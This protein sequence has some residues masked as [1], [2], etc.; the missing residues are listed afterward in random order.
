MKKY[1]VM[2]FCLSCF[3]EINAQQ[4]TIIFDFAHYVNLI[5]KLVSVYSIDQY[6][7]VN[8]GVI[9]RNLYTKP[10]F[11][12]SLDIEQKKKLIF[13]IKEMFEQ[14]EYTNLYRFGHYVIYKMW[15]E[16]KEYNTVEI[17]QI[18]MELYLKYYFYPGKDRIIDS[19]KDSKSYFTENAK[20]RILEIL[21]N[22][23]TNEEYMVWLKYIK[24]WN[25]TLDCKDAEFFMKEKGIKYDSGLLIKI[26]DSL[27]NDYVIR[28]TNY[29]F[30]SLQ[31]G[32]EIVLLIGRLNMTECIPILRQNIEKCIQNKCNDDYI[33]CYRYALARLG[34]KEQR[35]YILDSLMEI[36]SF[37]KYDF[38]YFRDDAMIWRY[39]EVNYHS[40]K[41]IHLFS[42]GEGIPASLKTMS[43]I[44]PYIKD[45]PHTLEYP[46][47]SRD[48]EDDY[49]WAKSLYEWLMANKNRVKFD[50]EGDK[51]EQWPW[52]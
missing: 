28:H 7:E 2:I 44:F 17:Q 46:H 41:Q 43:D 23:K 19:Y 27:L 51:S 15:H 12:N 8:R 10:V 37:G 48:M 40:N 6:T 11:D 26:R 1:I 47:A 3:A 21:G 5:E 45:V 33:V 35:Q 49:K 13:K 32:S 34:D 30:E 31:I 4:D 39:I 50:Y 14:R 42:E 29:R 36:G 9:F 38:A 25:D 16:L 20:H 52:L 24:S 18:L 22:K